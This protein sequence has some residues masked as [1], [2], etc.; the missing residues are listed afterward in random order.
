MID[1]ILKKVI[2]LILK[3]DLFGKIQ[4]IVAEI[5]KSNLS[6]SEKRAK[7]L[8]EIVALGTKAAPF[9]INL[10]I[11]AAVYIFKSKTSKA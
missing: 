9:L 8:A 4:I 2:E 1:Y 10:G 7:A 5:G 3:G 6:G 11:E